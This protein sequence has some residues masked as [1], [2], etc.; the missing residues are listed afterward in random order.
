MANEAAGRY[1]QLMPRFRLSSRRR[2]RSGTL[3]WLMTPNLAASFQRRPFPCAGFG[4]RP[5]WVV[6][7][8]VTL[9]L[10][11]M[12]ATGSPIP[13]WH[14]EHL[15]HPVRVRNAG[16]S[17]LELAD[18]RS[19]RLPFIKTL[20]KD[21]PCFAKALVHGV[22]VTQ[23][24]EVYGLIDPARMCGNDPT[25]FYRKRVNLSD[26]AGVLYPDGIDDSV[27]HPEAKG[28]QG[29]LLHRL[30][31]S[32]GNAVWTLDE[33]GLPAENLRDT[34]VPNRAAGD[35]HADIQS[36]VTVFH[37]VVRTTSSTSR[38]GWPGSRQSEDGFARRHF[39]SPQR[40]RR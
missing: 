24:G 22:E 1:D 39:H 16:E 29:K 20:P 12:L 15:D 30:T 4:L 26:L 2:F 6:Y 8:F 11:H 19:I 10:M 17:S 9:S 34:G 21:D 38:F 28:V 40:A 32:K 31:R 35:C 23:S 37:L 13:L 14:I 5:L 18:G 36:S 27:I 33:G 3:R 25:I 7:F